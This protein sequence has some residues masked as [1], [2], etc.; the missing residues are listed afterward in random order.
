MAGRRR[1]RPL[2][3][4]SH[5]KLRE[6]RYCGYKVRIEKSFARL[7]AWLTQETIRS[8]DDTKLLVKR[9]IALPGDVVS[10]RVASF[11]VYLVT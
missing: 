9:I 10:T 2:V 11:N 5:A 3:R 7:T 1:L 6:E 4:A 8:P